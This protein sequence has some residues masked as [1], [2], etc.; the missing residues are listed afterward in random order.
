VCVCV[1]AFGRARSEMGMEETQI[2][3]H[4]RL[5][6]IDHT[7]LVINVAKKILEPE[8]NVTFR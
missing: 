4:R 2:T 7:Y 6:H 5:N 1:C 8:P 3:R